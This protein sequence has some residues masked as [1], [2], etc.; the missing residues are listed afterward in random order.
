MNPF[1]ADILTKANLP[2][3]R[4][5]PPGFLEKFVTNG[6]QKLAKTLNLIWLG[7]IQKNNPQTNP[8]Q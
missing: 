7:H 1:L 5:I 3:N 6:D 4:P 8:A 2:V